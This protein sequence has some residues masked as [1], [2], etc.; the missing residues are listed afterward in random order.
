MVRINRLFYAAAIPVFFYI[1]LMA[2]A[3]PYGAY[4]FMAVFTVGITLV[5]WL[6]LYRNR[7][8]LSAAW[9]KGK[10]NRLLFPIGLTVWGLLLVY[11]SLTMRVEL[12]WDYGNV[13]RAAY[14]WAREGSVADL[15]YF[16][17]YPNNQ[18]ILILLYGAARLMLLIFPRAGVEQ[19]QVV[20]CL[21]SACSIFVSGLLVGR[22][23]ERLHEGSGRLALLL[24]MSSVPLWLYSAI[25]YTDTLGLPILALYLYCLLIMKEK[26]FSWKLTALNGFLAGLACQIKVTILIV[27]LASLIFFVW[28]FLRKKC[29]KQALL[30]L[31]LSAAVFVGTASPL[32]WA[33]A[34]WV[35]VTPELSNA[36][37]FPA[38]HWVMMSM[39]TGS[40]NYN[41]GGYQAND[42]IETA[43]YKTR[44][45]KSASAGERLK[46]RI[47]RPESSLAKHIL[48][49]KVQRTWG[50]GMLAADD[51]LGRKPLR[52]G[53][54]Q[55]V[56]TSSGKYHKAFYTVAQ[57]WW[58]LMLSGVLLSMV[59]G[60]GSDSGA[61]LL[62]IGLF[63]I[64][65][66]FLFWECNSRYLT[67]FLPLFTLTAADGAGLALKSGSECGETAGE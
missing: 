40:D 31:L 11:F 17:R 3:A 33:A 26:G 53:F 39:Y 41:A 5:L 16:A 1:L 58:I 52:Q 55:E 64:F 54:W 56:F 50:E 2:M 19:L 25:C 49:R 6:I 18:A 62:H 8:R 9:E 29:V 20:G 34:K 21:I 23:G 30:F 51:Y 22:A 48:L 38:V 60:R 43:K 28:E 27:F 46:E 4:S 12:S 45:E 66:F 65:L 35:G 32:G 44:A 47:T 13:M 24:Y 42:V 36:H 59:K 14:Q 57:L 61:F 7:D 15:S 37:E 10:E 67:L 63:G